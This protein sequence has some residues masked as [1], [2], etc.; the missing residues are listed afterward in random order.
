VVAFLLIAVGGSLAG[1]RM[2][3]RSIDTGSLQTVPRVWAEAHANSQ[4]V[5]VM[6]I[7]FA[8]LAWTILP[9]AKRVDLR[10]DGQMSLAVGCLALGAVIHAIAHPLQARFAPD[11]LLIGSLTGNFMEVI[12]WGLF[13]ATL[14]RLVRIVP[15]R[16]Q[17]RYEK[18]ILAG[19]IWFAVGLVL[20]ILVRLIWLAGT[21]VVSV[22]PRINYGLRH[23]QLMSGSFLMAAGLAQIVFRGGPEDGTWHPP[24][25]SQ[26]MLW[27]ATFGAF[28][29]SVG[30]PWVGA[31]AP[32]WVTWILG[33]AAV[34]VAWTTIAYLLSLR[35]LLRRARN[36][37]REC[38]SPWR[39]LWALPSAWLVVATAGNVGLI[40][41]MV[42]EKAP[43]TEEWVQIVV[44]AF[45]L[46]YLL[47]TIVLT[48]R[49]AGVLFRG[50][51]AGGAIAGLSAGLVLYLVGYPWVM[52][53]GG[54]ASR[55]TAGAGGALIVLSTL[56]LSI[57]GLRSL[58]TKDRRGS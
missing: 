29:I 30:T 23:L 22:H 11:R 25:L 14:A 24:H 54:A 48:A 46:G 32:S 44:H 58:F 53:Q 15:E 33:A 4:V 34:L 52:G 27:A 49:G 8:V 36:G 21:L 6:G 10:C 18:S 57:Q 50:R 7:L 9:A 31:A 51:S 5:G 37:G 19:A 40:V 12:G 42:V 2:L 17:A 3:V 16:E 1:G 26:S 41:W 45:A 38:V 56:L 13:I 35:G 43:P 47:P 28:L 39:G 55:W 20:V